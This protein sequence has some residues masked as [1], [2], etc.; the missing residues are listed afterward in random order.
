MPRRASRCSR[1]DGA[2]LAAGRRR[3][4]G[5][6]AAHRRARS[7]DGRVLAVRAASGRALPAAV[8]HARADPA[9]AVGAGAY[10]VVRRLTRRLER[11]Q[12]AV[13][14]LGV[15][16]A[17]G[18]RRGRRAATR[19]RASPRASTAPRRAS[20]RWSARTSSLLANASHELR[21][22]LAR[23]RMGVELEDKDPGKEIE[24]DIAELD[25]L[26]DEILLASRLD[27]APPL[28]REEV[29][30][31]GAGGRGVRALR[32][33]QP[34]RRAR[35]AAGRPAAAAPHA[36]QPAGERVAPRQAAGFGFLSRKTKFGVSDAGAPIPDAEREKLF[37]PFYR[38]PGSSEA[39]RR[40]PRPRDRAPDRAPA[41]RRRALRGWLRRDL[42]TSTVKPF[43]YNGL[44]S[45]VIFGA[46]SIAQLPAELDRLGA[47][48]ALLLSTPEQKDSVA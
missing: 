45:R 10:P 15:G 32:G 16:R 9:L 5:R 11:L 22:P 4:A 42:L 21:T 3:T 6:G 19:W 8:R 47:K 12:A 18:A 34:R 39:D 27:A 30:L 33:R 46:G 48:R 44:P 31:L 1:A 26:I 20:R 17:V 23:I 37:E 40:R 13:E 28:E 41:R 14:S 24:R 29:D 35:H 7:A 2:R 43:V 38:R 36:A 25:A